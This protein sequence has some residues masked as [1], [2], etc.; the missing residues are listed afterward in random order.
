M[1]FLNTLNMSVKVH[2]IRVGWIGDD[3]NTIDSCLCLSA[4]SFCLIIFNY[5]PELI[6]SLN[7][8][9]SQYFIR[10]DTN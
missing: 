9:E 7:G 8:H 5:Q 3:D 4:I 2:M 1:A 6:Y 10:K